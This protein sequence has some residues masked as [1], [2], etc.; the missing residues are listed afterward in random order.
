MCLLQ[1]LL[2]NPSVFSPHI[3]PLTA[4]GAP[5]LEAHQGSR[6]HSPHSGACHPCPQALS[7]DFP[8][9][10]CSL[11][12]STVFMCCSSGLHMSLTPET[13]EEGVENAL[14]IILKLMVSAAFELT[15]AFCLIFKSTKTSGPSQR[16]QN[17][18]VV[19]ATTITI[20]STYYV[21]NTSHKLILTTTYKIGTV[22][23]ML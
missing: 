3:F 1:V 12:L 22:T 11:H 7:L 18:A 8:S 9:P 2:K 10:C 16:A 17:T 20:V 13:S 6:G 14:S 19:T 21:P 23:T 5:I 4:P 15:L